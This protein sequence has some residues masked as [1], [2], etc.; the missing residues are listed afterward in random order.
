M[1]TELSHIS[2]IIWRARALVALGALIAATIAVVVV[3][4]LPPVYTAQVTVLPDVDSSGLDIM[5]QLSLV[6]GG[7]LGRNDEMESLYGEILSSNRVLDTLI[8]ETWSY[9]GREGLSLYQILDISGDR[10]EPTAADLYD[11]RKG[12]RGRVVSFRRDNKT[13]FMRIRASVKHDP[14]LAAGLADALA[15]ELDGFI[16][17]QR[18]GK[19]AEQRGFIEKQLTEAVLALADAEG[20]LVSFEEANRS[21][22]EAP[23]LDRRHRALSRQVEA[24]TLIWSE[25]KRQLELARIEENRSTTSLDVLDRAAVPQ[26]PSSPRK[27]LIVILALLAGAT[28]AAFLV[29]LRDLRSGV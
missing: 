8:D 16:R 19:A 27:K 28:A 9:R 29:L 7:L 18:T 22:R 12:M 6:T 1:D 23:A 13:G 24:Q 10:A 25:L 5:N 3:L 21:Y 17:Q 26:I 15:T 14:V 2:R 20:E 4:L 11:L